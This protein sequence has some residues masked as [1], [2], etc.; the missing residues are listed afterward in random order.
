DYYCSSYG[1]SN[2]LFF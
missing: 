1:G 2:S